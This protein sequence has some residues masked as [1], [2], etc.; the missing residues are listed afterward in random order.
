M[1]WRSTR[2]GG[3]ALSAQAGRVGDDGTAP[4]GAVPDLD[5]PATVGCLLAVLPVGW[6]LQSPLCDGRGAAARPSTSG[7][8][9]SSSSGLGPPPEVL[10]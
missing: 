2:P 6:A 5:D 9:R 7:A 4:E 3:A 1:A 10:P 8:G